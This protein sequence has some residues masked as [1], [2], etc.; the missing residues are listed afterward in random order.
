M[1]LETFKIKVVP[2]REK[3]M[4]ISMKLVEER[5]EAEDVVQETFLRLWE[6]RHRLDDYNSVEALAVMVARN[7][8]LDRLRTRRTLHDA[9]HLQHRDSGDRNPA[10]RLEE[11]DAV[12][13]IRR[14]VENLP[15]LQQAIIRMKDIEGY[16]VEEI[17]AITGSRTETVRVNLSRARKKIR[18][19]FI[20]LNN[21]RI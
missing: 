16:E 18:E 6:I 9:C 3:L 14:L 12:Q 19:Q 7:L 15:A 17:A 1:E 2:L 4:R 11:Q 13:C 8:T 10:E 21:T 5:A 20:T